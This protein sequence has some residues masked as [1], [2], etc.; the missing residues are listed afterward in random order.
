MADSAVPA[1]EEKSSP[2][3]LKFGISELAGSLGD[4]GTIIPLIIGVSLA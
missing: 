1:V 4:F 3:S 2:Y